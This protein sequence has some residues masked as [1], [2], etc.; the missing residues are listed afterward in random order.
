MPTAILYEILF[1]TAMLLAMAASMLVIFGL[2]RV[3][4][5]WNSTW[6]KV[7]IVHAVNIVVQFFFAHALVTTIPLFSFVGILRWTP[8]AFALALMVADAAR[9]RLHRMTA[10]DGNRHPRRPAIA[11]GLISILAVLL[12][13]ATVD[14]SNG[15]RTLEGARWYSTVQAM[16]QRSPEREAI[17]AMVAAYPD[18]MNTILEVYFREVSAARAAHRSDTISPPVAKRILTF[19]LMKRSA[20][21]QAPGPSL[22]ALQRGLGDF[23][24]LLNSWVGQ[25]GTTSDGTPMGAIADLPISSDESRRYGRLIAAAIYAA[26]AGE[27]HPAGRSFQPEKL[28]LL[29]ENLAAYERH[30]LRERGARGIASD[31]VCA[32]VA[33]ILRWEASLPSDDLALLYNAGVATLPSI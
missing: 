8:I 6:R 32:N 4:R 22:A 19:T 5:G 25:C 31:N 2:H 15:K 16:R 14:S 11:F 28:P 7:A 23:G 13:R 29:M 21:A 17:D 33:D 24:Q 26:K 9:L 10:V 1:L 12:A 3:L 18:A 27:Q 20:I 30:R